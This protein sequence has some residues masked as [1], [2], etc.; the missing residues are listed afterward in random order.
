[1]ATN[2]SPKTVAT[3]V[4][5][6]REGCEHVDVRSR[7]MMKRFMANAADPPTALQIPPVLPC[8]TTNKRR[9][10]IG[11]HNKPKPKIRYQ[12]ISSKA[13]PSETDDQ[14]SSIGIEQSNNPIGWPPPC[15]AADAAP[16]RRGDERRQSI[17]GQLGRARARSD[18]LAGAGRRRRSP[19]AARPASRRPRVELGALMGNR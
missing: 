5:T 1:M 8:A 12:T 10:I 13:G 2:S 9:Q 19:P 14:L 15:G 18:P 16:R 7:R 6:R 17:D 4:R 11:S 3:C